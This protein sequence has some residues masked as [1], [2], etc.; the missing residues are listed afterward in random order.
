MDNQI[1]GKI[2]QVLPLATGIGKASGKE[3]K[4]Q[5]YILETF[6]QYPRKVCFNMWGDR[7]DPSIQ[8][9]DEVTVT[10]DVES[11]EFN[12]R[13]YTDVKAWRID[14]GITADPMAP[15]APQ[16]MSTSAPSFEQQ[17]QAAPAAPAEWAAPADSGDDLPF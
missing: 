7:I 9:G 4:K 13:W 15:A 5:E 17:A 2:I 6:D 8:E 3:W 1:Q 10:F 11:R 16:A 12:G 14:R